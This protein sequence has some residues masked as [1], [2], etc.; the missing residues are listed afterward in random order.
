[1]W[2]IRLGPKTDMPMWDAY[3][4]SHAQ[5]GLAHVAHTPTLRP[6]HSRALRTAMPS[7]ITRS[8]LVHSQPHG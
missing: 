2:P 5:L 8:C 7:S 1:M 3:V 4:G 6:P